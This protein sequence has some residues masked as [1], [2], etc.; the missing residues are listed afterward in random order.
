MAPVDFPLGYPSRHF[1]TFLLFIWLGVF[2]FERL[3]LWI[4]GGDT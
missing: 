4:L 1:E 3:L 2:T